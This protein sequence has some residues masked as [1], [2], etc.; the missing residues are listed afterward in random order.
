MS[1]P[2]GNMNWMLT[3]WQGTVS[4]DKNEILFK[5][6]GINYNN[7]E[8]IYKKG[9]VLYRQVRLT[10][11]ILY[12]CQSQQSNIEP[13][14]APR[15]QARPDTDKGRRLHPRGGAVQVAA[16]KDEEATTKGPSCD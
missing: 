2:S 12:P 1:L 3:C 5:R 11:H 7:E 14:C 13:V 16:G 9:S 6:F 4:S 8:E 15:S 10:L